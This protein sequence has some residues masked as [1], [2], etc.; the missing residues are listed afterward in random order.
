MFVRGKGCPCGGAGRGQGCGGGRPGE[1]VTDTGKQTAYAVR[2]IL[3]DAGN[4]TGKQETHG[5]KEGDHEHDPQPFV[6][7]NFRVGG[8]V[9]TKFFGE[10]VHPAVEITGAVDVGI[11][12]AVGALVFQ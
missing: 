7:Q 8:L 6:L 1:Q 4:F 10:A 5:S 3:P 2:D 12:Q 9:S 11:R